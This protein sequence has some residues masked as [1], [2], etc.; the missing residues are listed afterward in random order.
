MSMK[1]QAQGFSLVELMLA[2]VLGLLIVQAVISLFLT[3]SRN[4]GQDQK[5]A[6]L[7]DEMRFAIAQL[8]QDIEMAGFWANLLD[9]A[10][11]DLHDSLTLT[12]D[13]GPTAVTNWVYT[14]RSPLAT[15][16]NVTGSTANAAFSCIA[17]GDVRPGT[18]ILA[19]KRVAG[20]NLAGKE[21]KANN[22]YLEANASSGRLFEFPDETEPNNISPPPIS[23]NSW[24]YRPVIYYI[25]PYAVTAGDGIPNLCRKYLTINAGT[26]RMETECIASGVEDFQ[27]EFGLDTNSDGKPDTFVSAPSN[28]QLPQ[29]VQ[30]RIALLMRSSSPDGGYSNAKTYTLGNKA[31]YT[32]AD[33]FY[34][35][36]ISTTVLLRNPTALRVLNP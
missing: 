17:S 15:A 18:D 26:P 30:L 7:Q 14:E 34:R 5:V 35:R 11:I 21:F 1:R 12:T 19:L 16:D 6:A 23:S 3:S 25:Q 27:V 8:T 13:C 33:N 31:A 32:P 10:L 29:A 24:P 4:Y 36:V 20:H 9:P 22:V 2:L 28:V